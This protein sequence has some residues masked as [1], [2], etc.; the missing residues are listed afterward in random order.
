MYDSFSSRPTS[1]GNDFRMLPP[2]P[3][4]PSLS[5][6]LLPPSPSLSMQPIYDQS[7]RTKLPYHEPVTID[8]LA[9]SSSGQTTAFVPNTNSNAESKQPYQDVMI[10]MYANHHTPRSMASPINNDGVMMMMMNNRPIMDNCHIID[11]RTNSMAPM[12]MAMDSKSQRM[13][14]FQQQQPQP[15][16]MRNNS[17]VQNH[18]SMMM[19]NQS[20]RRRSLESLNTMTN[21]SIVTTATTT[22]NNNNGSP[23]IY[24]NMSNII[25]N[26]TVQQPQPFPQR[27]MSTYQYSN[28]CDPVTTINTSNP[29]MNNNNNRQTICFPEPLR[30]STTILTFPNSDHIGCQDVMVDQQTQGSNTLNRP[31]MLM[32][33][34]NSIPPHIQL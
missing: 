22:T 30:P 4:S 19:M 5:H 24:A 23:V 6:S 10:K 7:Q 11:K 12:I 34:T 21:E 1:N 32:M 18:N 3:P 9:S 2:P 16:L 14:T 29:M 25:L 28:N 26:S 17:L 8:T 31:K 20:C 33:M 13:H 15:N 27:L